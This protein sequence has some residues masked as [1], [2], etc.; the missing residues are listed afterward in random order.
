MIHVPYVYK[1]VVLNVVDGDTVDVR[2]DLGLH[3]S[4]V[5]R[6][7]LLG[8]N[9]PETRGEEREKGLIAK[10]ALNEKILAKEVVVKTVKDETGKYGRYLADIFLEGEGISV[11]SWMVEQRFASRY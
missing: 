8:I 11:N 1:A 5:Q 10:R 4:T 3:V 6:L 7:R 2:I 9:A